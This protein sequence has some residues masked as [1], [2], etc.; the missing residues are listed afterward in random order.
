MQYGGTSEASD[1]YYHR[2]LSGDRNV[3]VK[4]GPTTSLSRAVA[5]SSY[6]SRQKKVMIG[7]SHGS[8]RTNPMQKHGSIGSAD[9][10]NYRNN[11]ACTTRFQNTAS[12][13]DDA[14]TEKSAMDVEKPIRGKFI[15]YSGEAIPN[16]EKSEHNDC[17]QQTVSFPSNSSKV[18]ATRK[19]LPTHIVI[20]HND[21]D[22]MMHEGGGSTQ[23][24]PLVEDYFSVASMDVDPSPQPPLIVVDG[25]NIAHS[26]SEC[27]QNA[28]SSLTTALLGHYNKKE[29][30]PE[31]I[32]VAAQYFLSHGCRVVVVVPSF[33]LRAKPA[34]QDGNQQNALMVTPQLETLQHLQ[35]RGLLC[36]APPSD[37]D[38]AYAI[39][40]ARRAAAAAMS[41]TTNLFHGHAYLLS[42]DW[43]RDAIQRDQGATGLK[44]WLQYG[45]SHV[46]TG[47]G[48]I[49]YTFCHMGATSRLEGEP[50]KLDFIPN[51]RHALIHHIER[52]A[53]SEGYSL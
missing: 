34:S 30:D 9:S 26:Y 40:I 50:L 28:N 23:Q 18:D 43:F 45:S 35:K 33:W 20:G 22:D 31:G 3:S 16:Q 42:N 52:A 25:A 38:D 21:N 46:P 47:P 39:A 7:G 36:C 32:D 5:E 29:P 13:E 51:P 15:I 4:S 6:L 1:Q 12:S 27:K 8:S 19:I 17:S 37:D 24:N 10:H 48:R 49:S 53:V 2:E 41:Q 11:V 14:S 44:E